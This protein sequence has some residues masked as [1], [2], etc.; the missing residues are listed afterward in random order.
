M[1]KGKVEQRDVTIKSLEKESFEDE[2]GFELRDGTVV[3]FLGQPEGDRAVGFVKLHNTDGV[4]NDWTEGIG[5]LGV[6]DSSWFAE[7]VENF[8]MED[9]VFGTH[10]AL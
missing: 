7:L 10:V 1:V 4:E 3:F 5:S 2:G 6:E 8:D 9:A